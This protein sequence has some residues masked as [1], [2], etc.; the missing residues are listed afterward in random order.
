MA[1]DVHVFLVQKWLRH[2]F[3][4][5][6]CS[7]LQWSF[8]ARVAAVSVNIFL[9]NEEESYY[10]LMSISHGQSNWLSINAISVIDLTDSH[11]DQ[12]CC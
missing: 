11:T 7:K 2:V 4:S 8:V 12:R 1:I 9:P 6:T 5:I 3:M 10:F